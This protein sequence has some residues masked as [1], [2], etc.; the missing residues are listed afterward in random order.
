MMKRLYHWKNY[1]SIQHAMRAFLQCLCVLGLSV[2]LDVNANPAGGQVTSGNATINSPAANSLQINQTSQ[3]AIINWNSFNIGANESTHFQQP[4]GGVTLNRI[5]PT[6]G[7]SQIYGRLTATGQ[8]IL[9]NPAGIFFGPSAYVNVG[10]LIASTAAISDL[11][12]L[13]GHYNFAHE[14]PY[15][16]SIVNQ[17]TIIAANHGLVALIGSNVS[18][19]GLIQANLGY[20]VLASGGAFTMTFAANDLISFSVDK[21]TLKSGKVSNTGTLRANGGSV[22]VTANAAQVVLD[23]V[24]NMQG[25]VEAKSVTKRNGE[26]L[27]GKI[28]INGHGSQGVV[29][30]AA[31]LD[32]SGKAAGQTGGS[33]TITGNTIKI[34]APTVV[35]VSGHA[36]GG[37]I[38]IGGNYQGKGILP[39]ATSTLIAAGTILNADA[40]TRGNGGNIIVWADDA[41]QFHG[42]IFARG[43]SV[44]GNGGFVETSGK[45]YL[46]VA[47]GRVNLS[48]VQGKTGTWLLDPTNI[49]IQT[50]GI[51]TT[52]PSGSPTN[53]YTSN[54]NN[55]ILTVADLEA[56]L[57]NASVLVQTG[58]SGSQAG[59]ITV[60][61]N[62]SWSN[63][64]TLTLSAY[65]NININA[66]ITN[67][68]GGS[69]VLR[70]DNMGTGVG[71]ISFSGVAPQIN[72][73]GGGAVNVYY[74]PTVFP[75]ATN[76]T[77]NV[78]VSGSS[79]FTPYI[80]VNNLT[81]LQNMQLDVNGNY[82][83]GRNI[84]AS[85]TSGWNA[86]AGFDPISTFTG[87][88]DGNNH[89]IANLFI[90]RP[91]YHVGLFGLATGATISNVGVVNANVSGNAR[92]GILVGYA[93]NGTVI[94][95]SYSSGAVTGF[96]VGGLV[97]VLGDDDATTTSHIYHSYSTAAVYGG[98]Y[99]G[100]LV[101]ATNSPIDNSYS[102]GNVEGGNLTGGFIGWNY[103]STITQSY[104][105][106]NVTGTNT[107]GGFIGENDGVVNQSY[108]YG[109]VLADNS[110]GG[111]VGVNT[112]SINNSY[113]HGN[114]TGTDVIGGLV[115]YNLGF[116]DSTYSISKV[117]SPGTYVGGLVGFDSGTITNSYWDIDTSGLSTSP[118]GIGLTDAQMKNK[119]NFAG[120]DFAN[121]WI[122]YNDESYP[123]MRFQTT[124]LPPG[125]HPHPMPSPLFYTD[126]I[127]IP[128]ILM[129]RKAHYSYFQDLIEIVIYDNYQGSLRK[130]LM[131]PYVPV[132]R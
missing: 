122:N 111:F 84:D 72:F 94:T 54:A 4:R 42:A 28:V 25:F 109:N 44:S 13:N 82:A 58:S 78:S 31:Y 131:Q 123:F 110:A 20:V 90:N 101:G 30:V 35:D 1:T 36:G 102:T 69:L 22:L 98:D 95:N 26:I 29:R 59:D 33:V 2:S 34:D 55:S 43:G 75:V 96:V 74:N 104:S 108:S 99:A 23:N 86:G 93:N 27:L 52:V 66:A 9:V 63:A 73:S 41:S 65:N 64:N 88:F 128:S 80:L 48:A 77:G 106:G 47:G 81:N 118:S 6:S 57:G 10:G 56:A 85:A 126:N 8:I 132:L 40:L 60:L 51:T 125:P 92:V 16:G 12:F 45:N 14:E 3:R 71:T 87:K 115:G 7:V 24:I 117:T 62:V 49:T 103:G 32:A 97:G 37:S 61:N 124:N 39:N 130:I 112:G 46:D 76:Y 11:N 19:T 119:D 67:S 89:V 113:S 79:T 120:F 21:R 18:N 50:A 83:L 105:T 129:R 121:I 91:I 127:N 38:A 53:S 70:A 100:G 17:G 114:V 5:N 15:D 68:S 107:V 116:I